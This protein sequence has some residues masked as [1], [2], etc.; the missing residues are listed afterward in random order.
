MSSMR[1]RNSLFAPGALTVVAALL[2]VLFFGS[3]GNGAKRESESARHPGFATP[4]E[5]GDYLEN[6]VALRLHDGLR[7]LTGRLT[8]QN[9]PAPC[10]LD[11][12]YGRNLHGLQDFCSKAL[13]TEATRGDPVYEASVHEPLLGVLDGV[14]RAV[15]SVWSDTPADRAILDEAY[16]RLASVLP[17]DLR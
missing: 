4:A 2:I 1:S 6:E 13:D 11:F 9:C 10:A 3:N 16:L 8:L 17:P 14:C 12:D 15:R 5:L 7:R